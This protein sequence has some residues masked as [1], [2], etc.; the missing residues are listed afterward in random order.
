MT[1]VLFRKRRARR[2]RLASTSGVRFRYSRQKEAARATDAGCYGNSIDFYL[3]AFARQGTLI[4]ALTADG[5][6]IWRTG[7]GGSGAHTPAAPVSVVNGR[8]LRLEEKQRSGDSWSLEEEGAR[9]EILFD[10]KSGAVVKK[11]KTLV[12]E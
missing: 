8:N 4:R 1:L 11:K 10:S 7:I 9:C 12:T 6:E 2:F 3:K 5:R